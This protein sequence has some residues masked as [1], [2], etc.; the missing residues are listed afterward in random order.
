MIN[1][2]SCSA[3]PGAVIFSISILTRLILELLRVLQQSVYE[4]RKIRVTLVCFIQ[5]IMET[6]L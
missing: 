5:M 1:I 4:L 3:I 2:Q 6:L